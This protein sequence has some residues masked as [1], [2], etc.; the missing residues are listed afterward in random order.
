QGLAEAVNEGEYLIPRLNRKQRA[1]AIEG[2]VKVGG[3]EIS[4]RLKQQL[5]NDIG[6]DPDQ[7]PILQHALMRMWDYWLNNANREQA[8]DLDHYNAIGRMTEALSRHGDEVY[9]DLPD[10]DHR[11]L[12]MKLFKAITEKQGDGRGVRRPLP[13]SEIDE[14]TGHQREKMLTVIDAYRPIGRTFIMP[15]ENVKIHD[16]IIID[17]SHESLMRVWQRLKNWV[18]DEAD[19]ARIYIRLC[20]TAQLHNRGEA[21]FY[22]DPDLKIALAWR[23]NNKPNANWGTRIN[24]SFELAMLFLD[25]SREDFEAEQ[26]AKEE[27]RKRELEQ[28]KA[29]AK[30]EKERAEIQRKSAKRNKVFAGVL[31]LLAVFAGVMAYQATQA[32][33]RAVASEKEAKDNLSYSYARNSDEMLKENSTSR[34]LALLGQQHLENLEYEII[35]KKI[36]NHLNHNPFLRKSKTVFK[37]PEDI[38]LRSRKGFIYTTNYADC[39]FLHNSKDKAYVKRVNIASGTEIFKT[40]F[41]NYVDE[42][43]K[44]PNDNYIFV[45]GTDLEGNLSGIAIDGKSGEFEK[46]YTGNETIT[47]VTGRDDLSRVIVGDISGNIKIYNS[48]DKVLFEHDFKN[49]IH[50]MKIRPNGKSVTLLSL[51]ND[52]YYD[53]W[54]IDLNTFETYLLYQSPRDQHRWEAWMQYSNNGDYILQFGGDWTM[55]NINVFDAN[56][57]KLLWSNDTSHELFIITVDESHDQTM[58]TTSGI[59]E[60]TRVWDIKTGK[61]AMRP[62]KHEGG[63]WYSVFSPDQTK[64]ATLT[65]NNDVWVWG[66]RNKILLNH[67]TRQTGEILGISFSEKGD[68]LY[69]ASIDGDIVEWDLN[70]STY[71]PN[72]LTHDGMIKTYDM[73]SDGHFVVTGGRDNKVRIWDSKKLELTKEIKFENEVASVM[74]SK[75]DS[76]MIAVEGTGYQRVLRWNLFSM[77]EGEIKKSTNL[78][79]STRK[80]F[81]SKDCKWVV[82]GLRNNIVILQNTETGEIVQEIK[83]HSGWIEGAEFSPTADKF[84]TLAKDGIARMF[85][86]ETGKLLHSNQYGAEFGGQCAFSNDGGIYV[87]YCIFGMDSQTPIAYDMKTGKKLFNL[88]HSSGVNNLSFTEDDQH[89]ISASLDY[90]AKIWD[91]NDV[92]FPLQS[93]SVG[94]RVA[95]VLHKGTHPNRIF[96]LSID[97]N[98]YVYDKDS[99]LFVDGPYRGSDNCA[100][101]S[102]N[103]KTKPQADYFLAINTPNSVALWPFELSNMEFEDT[104]KFVQFSSEIIGVKMDKTMSMNLSTNI[105]ESISA[106]DSS[107]QKDWKQWHKSGSALNSP[108]STTDVNQYRDFLISQNTLTSLQEI[109]YSYPMDKQVMK[110]YSKKLLELSEDQTIEQFKR[111][112]YKTSAVWYESVSK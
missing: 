45:T 97:G 47:A 89:I 38:L 26:K 111:D 49:K 55:G 104:E 68:K 13:F 51:E 4:P 37:N 62:L 57:N 59:D 92:Q 40:A 100:W 24:N 21:G 36:S 41:L 17:I 98:I 50:Q 74:Y 6:D 79:S 25:D 75:D 69:A 90:T 22:R 112:R 2:P 103:L 76:A 80:C 66:T 85:D 108:F 94:S 71:R 48:E 14:I 27:A 32:E 43:N 39:I 1:R 77:P 34:S 54:T 15:G 93:Y 53:L 82:Y 18:N 42:L 29:L 56:E 102:M 8:L 63:V 106:M 70:V 44:S 46:K 95:S 64:I 30:A 5:L 78:P 12:C 28:A 67:P 72:I 101:F 73:S 16:K 33:K 91:R 83:S 105:T 110:L 81:V 61:E 7:L 11:L 31:F 109:L 107:E 52:S 58:I 23:D 20:E 86:T 60:T 99:A 87:L 96:T 65:A 88:K 19:S 3:A 35:P 10:D 9:N 84:I